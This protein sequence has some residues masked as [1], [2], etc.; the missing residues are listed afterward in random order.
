MSK[1]LQV[2]NVDED[3][4]ARL[5]RRAARNGRSA[6]AEH[7]ELLRQALSSDVEPSFGELAAELRRLTRRRLQTPSEV[8]QREGRE[9]R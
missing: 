7:R 9:E 8:L 5:K 2:R 6:E 3:L 4:V 1:S